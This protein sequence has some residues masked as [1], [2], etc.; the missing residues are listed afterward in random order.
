M[1]RR[2]LLGVAVRWLRVAAASAF[3]IA[4]FGGGC[5]SAD[6]GWD[7]RCHEVSGDGWFGC[8]GDSQCSR[9]CT[10]DQEGLGGECVPGCKT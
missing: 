9:G 3:A 4:L 8:D 6:E 7:E 1:A 5:S 10:C 2:L